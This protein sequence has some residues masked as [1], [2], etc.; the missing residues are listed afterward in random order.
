MAKRIIWSEQAHIERK[1]ILRFWTSHN[2]SQTYSIKLNRLFKEEIQII[3]EFPK[4]G[5]PTNLK[6]IRAK[7]VRD[8]YIFY[9]ET[10]DQIFIIT[11]WDTRQNPN[12]QEKKIKK[13]FS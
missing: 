8:Y 2:K 6:D 10:K 11:I 3:S 12:D 7:I 9:Q 4:I 5:K 1:E 13:G